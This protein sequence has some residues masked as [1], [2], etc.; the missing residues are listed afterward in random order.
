M[1]IP[2]SAVS[3]LYTALAR[4]A[5][6]LAMIDPTIEVKANNNFDLALQIAELDNEYDVVLY[7]RDLLRKIEGI[8]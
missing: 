1:K 3:D 5:K 2:I 4:N 8:K 6:K 7:L